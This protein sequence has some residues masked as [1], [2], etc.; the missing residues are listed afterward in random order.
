MKKK[1]FQNEKIDKSTYLLH[2]I[3]PHKQQYLLTKGLCL[4]YVKYFGVSMT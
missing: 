2:C 3:L 4:P 1:N